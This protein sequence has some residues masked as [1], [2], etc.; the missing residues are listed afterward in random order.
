MLFRC[1]CVLLLASSGV[2]QE[3]IVRP[4]H[5]ERDIDVS[6][7]IETLAGDL[8]Y[9]H[10]GEVQRVLASNNKLL[11]LSAVL[12]GLPSDY[13][14]ETCARVEGAELRVYGNGDPSMRR[15]VSRD[16]P[17]EFA[18]ALAETL[19]AASHRKF[20]TLVI[21]ARAFQSG[22]PSL[23][24][25]NQKYREYCAP[26]GALM[27]EGSCLQIECVSDRLSVYPD[28]GV[29][30]KRKNK[31]GL[32][33]WWTSPDHE[34]LVQWDNKSKGAVRVAVE[35][36]SRIYG[37]WLLRSLRR[38]GVAIA[39]LRFANSQEPDPWGAAAKPLFRFQSVWNLAEA[40]KVA[41]RDSDNTLTEVLLMTLGR[42][43][44]GVGSLEAGLAEVKRQLSLVGIEPDSFSQVDGSGMA[45]SSTHRVNLCAPATLVQLLREMGEQ[46]EAALLFDSLPI[47][48]QPGHLSKLCRDKIFQPNRVRA[49]TGWIT[50]ASSLTGYMLAP[51]DETVLLF[52]IVVNYEKDNTARTNN[53]RFRKMQ[54]D[55][56]KE[57]LSKWTTP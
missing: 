18:S 52:S 33:A 39:K 6:V 22:R 13:R 5:A 43:K 38:R 21:D 24:P 44:A 46:S 30:I 34:L 29:R 10:F 36:P 48:G 50:G 31:K 8:V 42:E 57:V 23:W 16:P 12:L 9:D 7:R 4:I 54:E 47:A 15:L 17:E 32:S 53:R 37:E 14:W 26:P 49:K 20:E 45:R 27:L 1:A 56:L 3:S 2:S 11:T 19:L 41:N 55:I 28:A 35:D 51:D 40:V 25:T